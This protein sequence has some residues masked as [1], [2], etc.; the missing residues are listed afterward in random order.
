MHIIFMLT[1]NYKF[2][3]NLNIKFDF[4]GSEKGKDKYGE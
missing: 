1:I 4:S 3:N 2:N